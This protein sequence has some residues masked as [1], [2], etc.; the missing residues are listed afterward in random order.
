MNTKARAASLVA[1][2]CLLGS[3]NSALAAPGGRPSAVLEFDFSSPEQGGDDVRGGQKGAE[4]KSEPWKWDFTKG[5]THEWRMGW[6]KDDDSQIT[7]FGITRGLGLKLTLDFHSTEFGDGNIVLPWSRDTV[8]TTISA[9]I[10]VPVADGKPQGPLKIGCA[11]NQ[12]WLEDS[13]WPSLTLNERATIDGV[14]FM[15]QTVTCRIGSSYAHTAEELVLRIGG[16]GTLFKGALYIQEIRAS[17]K[18]GKQ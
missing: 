6:N 18:L 7:E 16:Q 3:G 9:R 12:P 1:A 8:P 11:M 13:H 4:G 2:L 17:R 10:L 14:E 5:E 15:A